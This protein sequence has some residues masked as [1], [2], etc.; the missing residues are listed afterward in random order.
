MIRTTV[1]NLYLDNVTAK[2]CYLC[3]ASVPDFE[4]INCRCG[5][6]EN[7]SACS[8]SIPMNAPICPDCIGG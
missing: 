6:T 7:C 4:I 2:T 5:D 3:D 1:N 8:D